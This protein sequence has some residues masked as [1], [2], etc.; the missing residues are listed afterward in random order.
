MIIPQL[1][2]KAELLQAMT[3][4]LEKMNERSARLVA[5][6]QAAGK[7]LNHLKNL[8][9]ERRAKEISAIDKLRREHYGEVSMEDDER[10]WFYKFSAYVRGELSE[11]EAAKI[12][13][14]LL[15]KMKAL[16]EHAKIFGIDKM[17]RAVLNHL[18]LVGVGMAKVNGCDVEAA[19]LEADAMGYEW[20]EATTD[21][22]V[23]PQPQSHP[24]VVEIGDASIK[25]LAEATGKSVKKAI[26]PGKGSSNEQWTPE[27]KAE[28]R[29][30]WKDKDYREAAKRFATN[31]RKITHA[32]VYEAA[33]RE[34]GR[35]GIASADEFTRVLGAYSDR[36]SR[37][38]SAKRKKPR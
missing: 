21:S 22:P 1:V 34:L 8:T 20:A 17:D 16:K 2:S 26:K 29:R 13:G 33:K 12:F 28:A 23:S 10:A 6:Q 5:K 15:D 30:I 19:N 27:V 38:S 25:K 36:T 14:C 9:A 11:E 3:K 18:M 37:N 7:D 24:S 4:G 31:G 32:N 35:I